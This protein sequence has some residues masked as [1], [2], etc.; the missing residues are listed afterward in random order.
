LS[1]AASCELTVPLANALGLPVMASAPIRRAP[2]PPSES[3][4]RS[5]SV[6]KVIGRSGWNTS[7]PPELTT[8]PS[9]R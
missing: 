3:S 2:E 6:G 7:A 8:L 1:S 5:A 9:W 4:T